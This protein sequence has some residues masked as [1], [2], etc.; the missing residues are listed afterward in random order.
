[1]NSHFNGTDDANILILILRLRNLDSS[2]HDFYEL[3][4]CGTTG[5]EKPRTSICA[6]YRARQ[7]KVSSETLT[8]HFDNSGRQK[9]IAPEEGQY[10]LE[11]CAG[12]GGQIYNKTFANGGACVYAVIDVPAFYA[13]LI[14]IGQQG[15]GQSV[16]ENPF[17]SET[18]SLLED[19]LSKTASPPVGTGGGGATVVYTADTE[20]MLI[21]AGGGGGLFE[22]DFDELEDQRAMGGLQ[23]SVN[24]EQPVVSRARRASSYRGENYGN[25]SS[26]VAGYG[27]GFGEIEAPKFGRSRY[28]NGNAKT[29][30]GGKCPRKTNSTSRH[31]GGFG[32]GGAACWPGGA[33]GGAGYYAG[34]PGWKQPGTGGSS[35]ANLRHKLVVEAEN[36]PGA[37]FGDG[38][39]MIQVC[40]PRCRTNATC[41][42]KDFVKGHAHCTCPDGSIVEPGRRQNPRVEEVANEEELETASSL[43]RASIPDS[44]LPDEQSD[45]ALDTAHAKFLAQMQ[46]E[47]PKIERQSIVMK[48][49]LGNGAFGEVFQAE[50]K[51]TAMD[52][53]V[54][55]K[56][57]PFSSN[58][59]SQ[60]EFLMEAQIMNKFRHYNIVSLIGINFDTMPRYIVL[61]LM[62]GG[63]LKSF[64]RCSRSTKFQNNPLQMLMMDLVQISLDVAKGCEFLENHLFVHRDL[65]AR[66]ILLTTKARGRVA[67][68]ADFGMAR[69]IYKTEYYRKGGRAMLPVKWMP[70]EALLDGYFTTK[71]DVWSYGV[72]LWEIFSLGCMPYPGRN[73]MEV[74]ELIINGGRLDGPAGAPDQIYMIMLHCWKT[75]ETDRPSFRTI[76]CWLITLLEA[77]F[78][79]T[80]PMPDRLASWVAP[81]PTAE[82]PKSNITVLTDLSIYT[83]SEPTKGPGGVSLNICSP[84]SSRQF[85]DPPKPPPMLEE[86]VA[87]GF[88]V[89]NFREDSNA[90]LENIAY[91]LTTEEKTYKNSIVIATNPTTKLKP[92]TTE[93]P[94]TN[95][96][97]KKPPMPDP[98]IA[99]LTDY[100]ED[101][102]EEILK[103]PQPEE[104]TRQPIRVPPRKNPPKK[105]LSPTQTPL[106]NEEDGFEEAAQSPYERILQAEL[107]APRKRPTSLNISETVGTPC[108]SL[109]SEPDQ[110]QEEAK[111]TSPAIQNAENSLPVLA[112]KGADAQPTIPSNINSAEPQNPCELNTQT[113]STSTPKATP[114]QPTPLADWLASQ[115]LPQE[116]RVIKAPPRKFP[117]KK[118]LKTPSIDPDDLEPYFDENYDGPI[119]VRLHFPAIPK[120]PAS[121]PNPDQPTKFCEAKVAA[122]GVTEPPA[123]PPK[124]G[125][126]KSACLAYIV[127]HVEDEGVAEQREEGGGEPIPEDPSR[128]EGETTVDYG[129]LII[130]GS[131]GVVIAISL[132]LIL[133]VVGNMIYTSL[134][135][136]LPASNFPPNRIQNRLVNSEAS[137]T[138]ATASRDSTRIMR[139]PKPLCRCFSSTASDDGASEYEQELVEYE[140]PNRSNVSPDAGRPF[141]QE[142]RA[143]YPMA[144]RIIEYANFFVKDIV[145]VVNAPYYWGNMDRF[146]AEALLEGKPEGTFLL[147]D[148]AQTAYLYSVSFRRYQRTLHA[149]IEQ[150]N[151]RFGFDIHDTGVFS[152]NT[153]TGLIENYGDPARCLFFEPLLTRPLKRD[154]MVSLQELAR[155]SI[156]GKYSYD[157][158]AT[159]MLPTKLKNYVRAIHYMHPI[160]TTLH[161]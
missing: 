2:L 31:L 75:L 27:I 61:E 115:D 149:R 14:L 111:K 74:M 128:S 154:F 32:G 146:Q 19:I 65:A 130:K 9:W 108:I 91:G 89:H 132:S 127:D 131:A 156:A 16:S 77:P 11:V 112:K 140:L 147:R 66:N 155:A 158:V 109:I 45:P 36:H 41:K 53:E 35:W 80:M 83:P 18:T 141:I 107:Q 73:N 55:V 135:P 129:A 82:T 100:P 148:S 50:L 79:E 13:L 138:Q 95:A 87:I 3:T 143:Q 159:L 63:D 81:T 114:A 137:Q 1:M 46:G 5:A 10:R 69:D 161:E 7:D 122:R 98:S 33:G 144:H 44:G 104:E 38:H 78:L 118:I 54:A 105:K 133:L 59:Q 139:F 58:K 119:R 123:R 23:Y 102:P 20:R 160:R 90:L 126:M 110:S 64:L 70:P 145:K 92:G 68:I 47:L 86:A 88:K 52:Q 150:E 84:Y 76:C 134:T 43:R 116:Q 85:D 42:F 117:P 67:K 56:T 29:F 24:A 125:A 71:T 94:V 60:D 4:S 124:P 142:P 37:H 151:H 28:M 99:H 96:L 34:E 103:P 120:P 152:S 72:L 39:V 12:S 121:C 17:Y 6:S 15:V 157:E 30:Q 51:G 106:L 153:I 113:P 101:R 136:E 8:K 26:H 93:C 49:R 48:Q 57:L 25:F 22:P 21:V 62:S 97:R 40:T